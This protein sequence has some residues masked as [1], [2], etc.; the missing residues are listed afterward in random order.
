MDALEVLDDI[1]EQ[2][3]FSGNIEARSH[4]G[5]G[6]CWGVSPNIARATP[7]REKP[8]PAPAP[9]PLEAAPEAHGPEV[10]LTGVEV[11]C[12]SE[13]IGGIKARLGEL[14]IRQVDFDKLAGF[15]EGLTGKVFGPSQVKRLG[16]EKMFDAIRAA[17]LKLRLEADPEQLERM[18]KQIAENCQPRQAYQARMNNH[19]R[20]SQKLVDEVLNHLASKR[21]GMAQLRSAVKKARSNWARYAAKVKADRCFGSVSPMLRALPPPREVGAEEE[22]SAA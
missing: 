9:S 20:I 17:G 18:Q 4:P 10:I 7:A 16:P 15:A 3:K 1:V 13:L 8:L 22:A 19:S 2:A 5:R 12:Y 11:T 21:G 6:L 14:G